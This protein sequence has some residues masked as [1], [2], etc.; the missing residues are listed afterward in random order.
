MADESSE[1]ERLHY[2]KGDATRPPSHEHPAVI[3][4]VCNDRGRWG[5]GFVVAVSKRWKLPALEYRRAHK[6]GEIRLGLVQ[7]VPVEDDGLWVANMV[8]QQGL[9]RSGRKVQY[10]HLETCLT[11]VRHW[12]AAR[13]ESHPQEPPVSVH[14]PRIG[15]GLG[16]GEWSEVEKI[17]SRTLLAES[18]EVFVYD[19]KET[20]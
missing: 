18:V 16:G 6:A 2:I 15:C 19:W 8:A 11:T 17:V 14:M 1:C 7:F 3:A 10:N 12:I 9:G 5:K 20:K 4:H 13:A